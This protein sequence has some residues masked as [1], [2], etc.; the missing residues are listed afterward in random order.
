MY[1]KKSIFESFFFLIYIFLKRT[2]ETLFAATRKNIVA[3]FANRYYPPLYHYSY[4]AKAI[5]YCV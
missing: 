4:T 3:G 5:G 2:I 1:L